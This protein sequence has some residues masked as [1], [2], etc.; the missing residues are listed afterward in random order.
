MTSR[1]AVLSAGL[2]LALLPPAR[3]LAATSPSDLETF[4]R[5]RCAPDGKSTFW[6]YSG[7]VLARTAGNASRPLL[8]VIGVSR[9]RTTRQPDGTYIYDLIEAGYYG[10]PGSTNIADG[11]ITN[12]LT[13]EQITPEN[14]IS[15]QTLRFYPDLEVKPI[16][17]KLPPGLDYKGRITPPDIKHGRLWMAEELLIKLPG[18]NGEKSKLLNSLA[19]FEAKLSDINSKKAFVPASLQY[20]T[21]N[22]FRPWMNMGN[23]DGDIISRLNGI[24]LET[25]EEIPAALRARVIKDHG[26]ALYA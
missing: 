10:A 4:V 11:P 25:W 12:A 7:H 20:T 17:D 18:R 8:S 21:I 6:W 5:L 26:D 9:S 16:T 14:Y 3:L 19:N 1:R 23:A 15:P 24:K 2:G 13:G 22:S